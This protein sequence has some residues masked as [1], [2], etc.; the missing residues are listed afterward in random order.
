MM[1]SSYNIERKSQ[2]ILSNL[3]LKVLYIRGANVV[4]TVQVLTKLFALIK[5]L[6]KVQRWH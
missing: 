4:A 3:Q 6:S 2:I 1:N 5:N